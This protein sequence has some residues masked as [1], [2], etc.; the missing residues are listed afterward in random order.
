MKNFIE[1]CINKHN[2][3]YDYS[4]TVYDKYDV[5]IVIT[6]PIHGDF[7]Q[8]SHNHLK[9]HGCPKC[10]YDKNRNKDIIERFV[11][12]HKDR[13]DYSLVNYIDLKTPVIII[14]K[15]HGVFEQLPQSHL[16]GCGCQKCS[17][18]NRLTKE[19]FVILSNIKHNNKYDYSKSII[20]NSKT[21]TII[22]CPVHGDFEQVPTSHYIKGH[23]CP[24]CKRSKGEEIIEKYL[25][26]NNIIFIHQKMFDDC[27]NIK[28]LPFDFYLP[29]HNIC[30][31]YDGRQ[32]FI[33]D[34]YINKNMEEL[35]LRIM[36]D[37]IKNEYCKNN[38]IRLI[39][40]KYDENIFEKINNI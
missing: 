11:S 20:K 8:Y 5:R 34:G 22:T 30:I 12:I 36:C 31:E 19:K 9:G 38:N 35:D 26:E 13:Y 14:C 28:K 33:M 37:E 15:E 27:K 17:G 7:I 32:H 2:N 18:N 6:C 23:G 39:R 16:I 29:K 24:K 1:K 10:Y 25:I 21:K 3:K 4:K 40:I